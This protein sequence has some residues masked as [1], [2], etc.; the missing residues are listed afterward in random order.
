MYSA[1]PRR[2]CAVSCMSASARCPS[3]S[4]LTTFIDKIEVPT[5]VFRVD[6]DLQFYMPTIPTNCNARRQGVINVFIT[7]ARFAGGGPPLE[8]QGRRAEPNFSRFAHL[9]PISRADYEYLRRDFEIML[10][11]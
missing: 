2:L 11:G 1:A 9:A 3:A 6:H 7:A 10:R 4:D 5:L 8:G